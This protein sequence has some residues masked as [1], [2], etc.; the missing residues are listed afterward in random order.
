MRGMQV[1]RK[2]RL[3]VLAIGLYDWQTAHIYRI[4]AVIET[5]LESNLG[6]EYLSFPSISSC[7]FYIF[8]L[9]SSICQSQNALKSLI[10]SFIVC[11]F[12]LP[13][14]SRYW[15]CRKRRRISQHL[16][17]AN[18]RWSMRRR[19]CWCRAV[20]KPDRY[21]LLLSKNIPAK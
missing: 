12:I 16:R 15:R 20:R 9:W 6:H 18:R 1:C 8:S 17:Q 11:C 3:V 5:T 19:H 7:L 14:G 13:S 10:W 2:G 21:P 4:V